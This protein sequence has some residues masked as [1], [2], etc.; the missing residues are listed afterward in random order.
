ML[1]L[2]ALFALTAL[3]YASVGF[4][5]G[6]TYNA[7]L[8]LNGTDFR[9]LPAIAL[10]C[11]IIVVAGGSWRFWQAGHVSLARILPWIMLSVP[12]AWLGGRLAISETLFIGALGGSLLVAGLQLAFERKG[13]ADE[14]EARHVA[15]PL[16]YA[17]GGGIGFLS[18]MVGIGGGIFLAPILYLLRWGGPREIAGTASVFILVNSLA[19]LAGQLMKLEADYGVASAADLLRDYWL[20]FPAVLIGGQIGSRLGSTRIPPLLVKR[21][22]AVLILYVAARLL[23]RWLGLVG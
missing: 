12:A 18:G 6:S 3:L 4:G 9:I 15:R 23:W 10:V 21:L 1:Q 5:G 22:T 16:S 19:G 7:L 8:V 17:V 11:N 14:G 20:L 2:A 13:A